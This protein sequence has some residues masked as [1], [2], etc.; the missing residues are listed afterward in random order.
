MTSKGQLTIPH[1]VRIDMHLVAGMRIEF[2][3]NDDGSY[4]INTVKRPVTDLFGCIPY[5]GPPAT[6]E[7]MNEA[8]SNA[9]AAE[10][11]DSMTIARA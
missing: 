11:M 7:E 9:V 10:V 4:M 3:R 2:A 1:D 8:I 5:Q 6:V